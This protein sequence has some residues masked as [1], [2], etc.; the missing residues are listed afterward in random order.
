M[1]SATYELS[2]VKTKNKWITRSS[3]C[4][5][6]LLTCA[7]AT[8][9]A[10]LKLCSK[11]HLLFTSHKDGKALR[12]GYW[13]TSNNYKCHVCQSQWP[14]PLGFVCFVPLGTLPIS[15][16][17]LLMLMGLFLLVFLLLNILSS[18]YFLLKNQQLLREERKR[19]K[20]KRYKRPKSFTFNKKK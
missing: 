9:M 20:R 11:Q 4:L 5:Q 14:G 16:G 12:S 17:S 10:F 7:Y 18:F 19:K 6:P 8:L 3:T 13:L 1:I 15:S 2:N